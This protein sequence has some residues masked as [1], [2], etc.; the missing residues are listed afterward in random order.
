MD[1][2]QNWLL[3]RN[4]FT[5]ASDS[6]ELSM[7]D[8]VGKTAFKTNEMIENLN[9]YDAK[10]GAKVS[11]I[12]LEQNRH[13][14]ATGD[15]TGSWF[16]ITT[17]SYSEPGIAGVVEQS[18]LDVIDIKA[19]AITDGVKIDNKINELGIQIG[20]S[21]GVDD[22]SMIQTIFDNLI[23]GQTV[24]FT[25]P[26]YIV[27]DTIT[28]NKNNIKIVSNGSNYY[29]N[30]IECITPNKLILKV[31]SYGVKIYN[32]QFKG[33]GSSYGELAT[34][35]G[36]EYNRGTD[37]NIDC[38]VFQCSFTRLYLGIKIYGRNLKVSDNI[39]SECLYG[40]SQ[41]TVGIEEIRG[42]IVRNNRFHGCGYYSML[43]GSLGSMCISLPNTSFG[44][45]IQDNY[46]DQIK[47]FF[48]GGGEKS[49]FSNNIILNFVTNGI[50]I[51]DGDCVVIDG[52][53]LIGD[54]SSTVG[55]YFFGG[56]GIAIANGALCRVSNNTITGVRY[57]SIKLSA[58]SK[59][60]VSNNMIINFNIATTEPNLYDGISIDSS[61]P[62]NLISN[63][64]VEKGLNLSLGR[65]GIGVFGGEC[66]M[67]N[68][69]VFPTNITK[70]VYVDPSILMYGDSYS[71]VGQKRVEYGA[72]IPTTG[73]WAQ[74]DKFI[75]LAP[76]L[77]YPTEY[78]CVVAGQD[79]TA[80]FAMS[81]QTINRVTTAQRP[82]GL[83]VHEQ[84][85]VVI[86]TTLGG[87]TITWNN[88]V[89]TDS[90]GTIV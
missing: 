12:D 35:N 25:A 26:H 50:N 74:G 46:A 2:L 82:T 4:K 38:E 55:Q 1:L 81:A 44:N 30:V 72:T 39:F 11:I 89:W 5:T 6:E 73:R 47:G 69:V 29:M 52:N 22:T 49:T 85:L 70:G 78:T 75:I 48:N 34:V 21:N 64:R 86:D 14:S 18:R 13:L 84:G 32:L 71:D 61:S 15:F 45:V 10:I 20:D 23:D 66:V 17:P 77:G 27:T 76:M 59:S 67:S 58:V 53:T 7:L 31:T 63:N 19:K 40:I 41:T 80:N 42:I 33:D 68:N 83:T 62:F 24:V 79:G 36:I 3:T 16:G 87:K 54:L 90:N 43:A 8:L 60:S 51:N 28:L 56:S 9:G 37:A 57:N 88:M 65:Y